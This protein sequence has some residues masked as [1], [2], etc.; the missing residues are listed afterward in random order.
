MAINLSRIYTRSGDK[1]ETSLA[2]GDRVTKDHPR[3]EAY[4]TSDEL[5][6]LIGRLRTQ[7]V[8]KADQLA[9]IQDRLFDLGTMLATSPGKEW[10]GMSKLNPQDSVQLEQW[11]DEMNL[12]LEPLKSFVLP[13]GSLLNAD[14]HIAR[15]VCR[16]FERLLCSLPSDVPVHAEILTYVNR[17][18]D[19]LFVLSRWYAKQDQVPE[20]LWSQRKG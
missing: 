11:I 4:G 2:S 3:L 10:P 14:A 7:D 18:S 15:A 9:E 12:A 8:R 5:C 6:C 1:G 16:R 13:G 19:Y 17:L 20:Y